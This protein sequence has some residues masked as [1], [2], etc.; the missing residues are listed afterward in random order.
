MEY[1]KEGSFIKKYKKR[2]IKSIKM[3]DP[4]WDKNQIESVV[5]EMIKEMGQ[6][7]ELTLDNNYTHERREST[8]LSVL[9]WAI[10][11]EPILA[12]NMTFY[13]TQDEAIN[14]V[15]KMLDDQ[16]KARKATKKRM[17][18]YVDTD[19]NKYNDLDRLQNN[20]KKLVNS[21]YGGSGMPSAAFYSLYSGP[22]LM[23]GT[24]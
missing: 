7:P 1:E 21:Y 24:V 10:D 9:D 18:Q 22:K 8:L 11:R 4:T 12:G 17:F 15:G 13:K 23:W 5:D 20:I 6:N 14:P 2:M 16:L 19:I 3:I